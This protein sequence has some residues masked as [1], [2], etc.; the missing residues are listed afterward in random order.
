M[1]QRSSAARAANR[2]AA[3]KSSLNTGSGRKLHAIPHKGVSVNS[4]GI[5]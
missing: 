2:E 1:A 3:L 5:Q 4:K